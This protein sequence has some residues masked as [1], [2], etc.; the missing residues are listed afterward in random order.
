LIWTNG[1][2]Q[3]RDFVKIVKFTATSWGIHGIKSQAR[4]L[5]QTPYS[6]PSSVVF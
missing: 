4:T 6:H 2:N 5:V 3:A 1:K